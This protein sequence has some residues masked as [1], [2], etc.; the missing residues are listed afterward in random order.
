MLKKNLFIVAHLDD[1]VLAFGGIL[2]K[3]NAINTVLILSQYSKERKEIAIALCEEFDYELHI[4]D[5]QDLE[6]DKN[7]ME[8]T[9][10]VNEKI[11]EVNPDRIFTHGESTHSD[12]KVTKLA[13]EVGSRW[14]NSKADIYYGLGVSTYE[15]IDSPIQVNAYTKLSE[16]EIANKSRMLKMYHTEVKYY[17]NVDT[18]EAQ[19]RY[20][21][22]KFGCEYAEP[23]QVKRVKL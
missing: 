3:R 11:A 1:E 6:F 7:S 14:H 16:R 9:R 5:F 4:A 8:I 21:G 19:A 13:V 23:Y 10:L 15:N 20:Y 22:Y 17:R 18:L 2:A 12:H